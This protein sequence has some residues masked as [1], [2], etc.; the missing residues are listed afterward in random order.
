MSIYWVVTVAGHAAGRLLD[1]DVDPVLARLY[2]FRHVHR[3]RRRNA[4]TGNPRTARLDY[5]NSPRQNG[6]YVL[7]VVA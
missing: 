7:F 3:P 2:E 6:R 1:E 5:P 4:N